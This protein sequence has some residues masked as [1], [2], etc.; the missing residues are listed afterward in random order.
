MKENYRVPEAHQY[1]GWGDQLYSMPTLEGA[2]K[3]T[4]FL[5]KRSSHRFRILVNI[6]P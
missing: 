1:L 2:G 6:N 3:D 5:R 4:T